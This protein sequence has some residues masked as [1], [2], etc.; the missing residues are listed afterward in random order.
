[1]AGCFDEEIGPCLEAVSKPRPWTTSLIVS[2]GNNCS[3]RYCRRLV[4]DIGAA[5]SHSIGHVCGVC[6]ATVMFGETML[7]HLFL[8]LG[9]STTM[10]VLRSH[11]P[12]QST[13]SLCFRAL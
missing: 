5:C 10:P 3:P 13:S 11:D 8:W 9:E 7:L 4:L 12:K 6:R 2:S 1:M